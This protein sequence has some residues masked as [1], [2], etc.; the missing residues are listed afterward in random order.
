MQ[1]EIFKTHESGAVYGAT[2][3]GLARNFRLAPLKLV[4]YEQSS[5]FCCSIIDKGKILYIIDT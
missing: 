2:I 4:R 5:L 3:F 1:F